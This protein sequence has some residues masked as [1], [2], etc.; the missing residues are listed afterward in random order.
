MLYRNTSLPLNPL[1]HMLCWNLSG[2]VLRFC[3]NQNDTLNLFSTLWNGYND[4]IDRLTGNNMYDF[5]CLSTG[6][7]TTHAYP[8]VFLFKF[9]LFLKEKI[10]SLIGMKLIAYNDKCQDNRNTLSVGTYNIHDIFEMFD[11]LISWTEVAIG[12]AYSY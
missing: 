4:F 7:S 1:I 10:K 6:N 9:C 8:D 12:Y 11:R 2:L 3:I 5:V